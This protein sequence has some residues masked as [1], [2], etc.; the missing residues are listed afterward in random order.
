MT[1]SLKTTPLSLLLL[2]LFLPSSILAY[3][4]DMT[5]YIDGAPV[6][7]SCG[8]YS[9]A[10]DD[11]VALSPAIMGRPA[12]PNKNPLCGTKIGI[13]NPHK[14]TKH[15][16]TVVDTCEG[17]GRGDIDV[18]LGLWRR[19]APGEWERGRHRQRGIDWGGEAVGG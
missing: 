6:L 9:G 5:F 11:V 2:L 3:K 4:G 16:A 8:W 13:W 15:W 18:S 10:N 1:P 17:C 19:V 7:G 14:K 12:N